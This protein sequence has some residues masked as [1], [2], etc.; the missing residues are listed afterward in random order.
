M[1][2]GSWIFIF[3][4][5]FTVIGALHAG[6]AWLQFFAELIFDGGLA[7]LWIASAIMLG[8]ALIRLPGS[9]GF[10]TAGA[11][12]LGIYSLAALILGLLGALNRWTALSLPVIGIATFIIT[13][14]PQF[15]STT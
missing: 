6:E 14:W 9:L 12:G 3:I 8:A 15:R 10:A 1:S 13:H 5:L 2:R 4:I 11:L 7:V